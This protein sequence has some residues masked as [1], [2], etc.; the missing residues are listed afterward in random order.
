[1]MGEYPQPGPLALE[2]HASSFG[3]NVYDFSP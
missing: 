1:M 3:V 2:S